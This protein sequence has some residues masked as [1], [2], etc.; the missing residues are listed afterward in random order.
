MSDLFNTDST[1]ADLGLRQSV[2]RGVEAM[3]FEHP[4]EIQATLIPLILEGKDVFGQARTGTGKTA[5]FAVPLLHG[6]DKST[7][8]QALILVPTREL[9]I[10]VADEFVSLGKHTPIR[11]LAVFGGKPIRK[12]INDLDRNPHIVVGTPGRVMDLHRR[13]IL[14]YNNIRWAVLDEVDRMLDIGF[15]DD[16]RAILRAIPKQPQA[17][18][19]SATISEEIEKLAREFMNDPVKIEAVSGSLTVAQVDQS[20]LTVNRWDKDRLLFHL[21]THEEPD[22][23]LV[24]C[25]MKLTV[26]RV[27][28][29]LKRKKVEVHAIHGDMPQGKRNSIMRKLHA[30]KLSVVVASDLA[31]RGLDVSGISHVVNYDL[32]EDP[33]IYVHRIGRTARAGRHGVAWSFVTPADGKLLTQIELLANKEIPLKSYPEFTPSEEPEDYRGKDKPDEEPAAEDIQN[34]LAGMPAVWEKEEPLDPSK[35]PDGVAPKKKP[36]RTLGGKV[37]TRKRQ[38]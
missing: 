4:T 26:D 37:R 30:G 25:R 10:Q 3:G 28:R 21:L 34:R 24:F 27:A 19:V 17:V 22:L 14:K 2:L 1:F 7:P 29:Y 35:F 13:G 15:R 18:F 36:K 6:A 32:P 38:W 23:T 9:A 33:E 11:T 16:I 12:N 20:Y 5:A 8:V 31:A